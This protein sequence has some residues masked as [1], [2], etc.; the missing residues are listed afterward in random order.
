MKICGL[1]KTTLLDFPGHIAATIFLGGC[2]F[3]CPYCHNSSLLKND[4][5]AL[6]SM[7]EVLSFLEKRTSV[8]EGVCITGG[9]PTLQPDLMLLITE[10]RK[11]GYLIKLDTNGYFPSRLKELCSLGLLDYVAMDIKSS[12]ERYK[13]AVGISALDISLIDES[14][15]FLM[16]N[17]VSYEFR[18]TV[19]KGLHRQEDFI[20]I[21]RWLKGCSKYYLQ[22]YVDSKQV[23]SPGFT[24]FSKE[25]LL[26]FSELLYPFIPATFLR[27]MDY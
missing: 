5:T 1:Q 9:E 27:G 13:E 25:E 26:T 16:E 22:N 15:S 17:P 21:G 4:V 8:L 24:S 10:I 7:K 6:Y 11:M 23:L 14:V 2:N 18:T 19:V 12:R 20:S 3:R